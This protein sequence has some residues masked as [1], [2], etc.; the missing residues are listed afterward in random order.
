MYY[1]AA[2]REKAQLQPLIASRPIDYHGSMTQHFDARVVAKTLGLSLPS[3]TGNYADLDQQMALQRLGVWGGHDLSRG[4]ADSLIAQLRQRLEEGLATVKQM[5]FLIA[6]GGHPGQARE[7]TKEQAREAISRR[8]AEIEAAKA[9]CR[10]LDAK[11]ANDD[12]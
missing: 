6:L 11:V 8:V 12:E 9:F 3:K 4:Q 2:D 5:A 10:Y 1:T 7:W